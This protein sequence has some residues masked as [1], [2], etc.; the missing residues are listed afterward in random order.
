MTS[1]LNFLCKISVMPI[2]R[3]LHYFFLVS[4]TLSNHGETL[5]NVKEAHGKCPGCEYISSDME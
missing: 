4:D 2:E 3:H 5:M 1:K